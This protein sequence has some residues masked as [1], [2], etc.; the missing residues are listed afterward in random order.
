MSKGPWTNDENRAVVS[1]YFAML[2]CATAGTPYNKAAMIRGSREKVTASGGTIQGPLYAR[3]KG[4]IEAKLMNCTAA[5]RDL[6][7]TCTT[8]DGF[9]YRALPNY[10]RSLRE[11]IALELDERQIR[12]IA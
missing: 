12:E 9:G 5:H 8:M 1:L 2:D 7:P 6:S 3:S 10:Q 4:S 11:A